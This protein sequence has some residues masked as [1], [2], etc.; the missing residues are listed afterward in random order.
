MKK[1]NKNELSELKGGVVTGRPGD[2]NNNNS[3]AGCYCIYNNNS[4]TTNTNST[5]GCKCV[6]SLSTDITR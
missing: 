2:A 3:T 6:C 4:V 5:D 1:L